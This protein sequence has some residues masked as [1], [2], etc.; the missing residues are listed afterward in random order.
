MLT[1]NS[2]IDDVEAAFRGGT[3]ETRAATLRRITDLFLAGADSFQQEHV[4]LFDDVLC[5]LVDKIERTALAELSATMA[6]HANAPP[7][8]TRDLSNHDDIAI[9]GPV[10]S[11]S[12]LLSDSH[13]VDIA[14][15][16][17]QLHLKAIASR[18]H[19]SERVSDVLIDRGNAIVLTTVAQNEGARFS[20]HGY[21]TLL[22][23]AESD[24]TL[25]SAVAARR[26]LSPEMFRKLVA[27][28]TTT[29]QQRLMQTADP[30][31]KE[32]LQ[33]VLQSVSINIVRNA[34]PKSNVVD[35]RSAALPAVDKQK[36]RTDLVD[37]AASGRSAEAAVALGALTDLTA[38]TIKT[39]MTRQ[40]P[41]A[42]LIVCKAAGLGWTT[43]RALLESAPGMRTHFHENAT[44]HMEQ[45]TRMSREAAERVL[46]FLKVRKAASDAELRQ[47]LAS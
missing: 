32:K 44:A 28:A 1:A 11:Q 40:Q 10:L 47:M 36:L 14:T 29:V 37:Y 46:R 16:K 5:R 33:G 20:T 9:A 13:L 43:V 39:L 41:E 26:D 23:K 35:A 7:R 12:P 2:V 25:A 4:S 21:R 45:Y 17:S 42:L 6:P 34:A 30:A 19:L 8:L 31:M 18:P 15:R 38:D 27:Q 22:G 3:A 24:A